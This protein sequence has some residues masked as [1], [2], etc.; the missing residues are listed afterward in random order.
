MYK[1]PKYFYQ[2]IQFNKFVKNIF[3]WSPWRMKVYTYYRQ[4]ERDRYR[5]R[6]RE[7]EKEREEF[8]ICKCSMNIHFCEITWI[9]NIS[10]IQ[11]WNLCNSKLS[12]E[13]WKLFA[14]LQ[15]IN[16]RDSLQSDP[17]Q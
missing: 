3:D 8:N 6:E 17:Y 1:S 12:I 13:M 4:K 16:Y 9:L 2:N 7:W 14:L 15:H 5:K 11:E 10:Q